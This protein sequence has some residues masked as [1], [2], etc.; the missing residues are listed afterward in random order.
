LDINILKIA[1]IDCK[2]K[3]SEWKL[4]VWD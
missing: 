1:I 2:M 4:Y 3:V